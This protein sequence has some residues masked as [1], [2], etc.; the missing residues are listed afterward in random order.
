MNVVVIL[1]Q[2]DRS[3]DTQVLGKAPLL[4][5]SVRPFWR[6]LALELVDPGS[7]E[8]STMWVVLIQPPETQIEGKGEEG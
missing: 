8:P 7:R 5:V 6:R 4:G 1:R 2:L 3:R